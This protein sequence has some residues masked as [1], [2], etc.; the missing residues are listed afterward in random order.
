MSAI[1]VA[2]SRHLPATFPSRA[3]H[4]A[5]PVSA[6]QP[7]TVT[8]SHIA[9]SP[10]VLPFPPSPYCTLPLPAPVMWYLVQ[11]PSGMMIAPSASERG[12][13]SPVTPVQPH[14]R[15]LSA[16]FCLKKGCE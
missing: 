8:P 11:T 9:S 14:M 5:H 3:D 16:S 6:L 10:H 2:P 4:L 1:W 13:T 7:D 15:S 12:R